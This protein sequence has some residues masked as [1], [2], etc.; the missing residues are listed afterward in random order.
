MNANPR[1]RN[2][3]GQKHPLW[4]VIL[5]ALLVYVVQEFQQNEAGRQQETATASVSQETG[6]CTR[7]FD[8]DTI[9]VRVGKGSYKVRIIG[10]DAMDAH[11]EEKAKKQ[12]AHHGV[13]LADVKLLS[14]KA[15]QTARRMLENQ[16]VLLTADP[17]S[18][19]SDRYGRR[20]RYVSVSGRDFGLAMLESGLAEPRR[21]SHARRNHYH[22]LARPLAF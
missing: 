20:L 21:E 11:N 15:E 19:D 8:G 13:Q 22:K 16:E 17:A 18:G 1:T 5:I 4:L 12:A 3:R 2:R 10:I 14:S 6:V 9:Q 7:V